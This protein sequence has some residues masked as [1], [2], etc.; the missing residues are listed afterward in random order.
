LI[1]ELIW[2]RPVELVGAKVDHLFQE[3]QVRS[4]QLSVKLDGLWENQKEI[5]RRLSE[6]QECLPMRLGPLEQARPSVFVVR[7]GP[8]VVNV[9]GLLMAIPSNLW[10]QAA[11]MALRGFN[12]IGVLKLF[13]KLVRPG[14][15][16]VDVG[17]YLGQF[18]LEAARL[19][20][21]NGKVYSF[22]PNP[23]CFIWLRENIILNQL[24]WNEVIEVRQCALAEKN[25]RAFLQHCSDTLEPR[26][27]LAESGGE[28]SV[29]V[30]T[31]TL[32]EALRNEPHVDVVRIDVDGA[33][34]LVVKGMERVITSNSSIAI[35]MRFRPDLLLKVGTAPDEVL[36]RLTDNGLSIF[37]VDPDT[38]S[39]SAAS[40]GCVC[41]EM[42]C[43]LLLT[44]A[45]SL[46][47][48]QHE[49]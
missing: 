40:P 45:A 33:E 23:H 27:I 4:E 10:H 49:A 24:N 36:S 8:Y 22:E 35:L 19:L 32:D 2:L 12:D 30:E 47:G 42:S 1:H 44:R 6:I 7:D 16:V 3:I 18:T 46:E 21:G 29:L 38:G 20:K 28:S 37:V 26:V 25:G 15:V 17:A 39:F 41:T 11:Q 34:G 31:M 14:M 43:T 48:F 13:R 9:D 5:S